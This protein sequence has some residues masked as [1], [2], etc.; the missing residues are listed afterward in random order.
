MQRNNVQRSYF[1]DNRLIAWFFRPATTMQTYHCKRQSKA[2]SNHTW[3][4]RWHGLSS[5]R[6]RPSP[7]ENNGRSI[8]NYPFWS[9]FHS[10]HSPHP[11]TPVKRLPSSHVPKGASAVPYFRSWISVPRKWR[12]DRRRLC[13]LRRL[14]PNSVLDIWISSPRLR[15]WKA[16]SVSATSWSWIGLPVLWTASSS[17]D[18]DRL[19]LTEELMKLTRKL[20]IFYPTDVYILATTKN[21][22]IILNR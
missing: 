12:S 17:R 13:H 18:A 7:K 16:E 3:S 1:C 11:N 4:N 10:L 5:R 20:R 21:K 6:A 22:E 14:R 19:T 15:S 9:Q 2:H 8:L